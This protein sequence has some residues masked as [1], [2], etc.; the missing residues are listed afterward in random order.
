MTVPE[1]PEEKRLVIMGLLSDLVSDYLYYNR[2]DSSEWP[3][4]GDIEQAVRDGVV[5]VGGLAEEFREQLEK[6]IR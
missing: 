5:T 4:P 6:H 2:K 1:S 3:K